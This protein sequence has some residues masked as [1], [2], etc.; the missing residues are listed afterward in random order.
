MV[1]AF[2]ACIILLSDMWAMLRNNLQ[3][4]TICS[5]NGRDTN[6]QLQLLT[7]IFLT[8]EDYIKIST[9]LE[10]ELDYI[11][12]L[13]NSNNWICRFTKTVIQI[14]GKHLEIIFQHKIIFKKRLKK[15]IVIVLFII[16][17][18]KIKSS[19]ER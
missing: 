12:E 3:A 7:F 10:L 13:N 15:T 1:S 8:S 2:T 17:N 6:T 4:W 18:I 19:D 16:S 11:S 9:E 14:V 5:R